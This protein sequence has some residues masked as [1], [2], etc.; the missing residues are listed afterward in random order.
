MLHDTWYDDLTDQRIADLESQV[1]KFR[2]MD[3]DGKRVDS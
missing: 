1:E 3:A 2:W